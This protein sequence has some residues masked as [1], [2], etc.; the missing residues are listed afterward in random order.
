LR[1]KGEGLEV[2]IL[3]QILLRLVNINFSTATFSLY[4]PISICVIVKVWEFTCFTY[5][6]FFSNLSFE[7]TTVKFC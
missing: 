5:L 6:G 2:L 4:I 3:T 1:K 7:I